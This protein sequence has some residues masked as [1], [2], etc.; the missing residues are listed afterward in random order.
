MRALLDTH[1][2]LWWL[3]DDRRLSERASGV[4]A[5]GAELLFSAASAWEIAIKARL[6]KLVVPEDLEPFLTDQLQR[7]AIE[8]LPVYLSHAMGVYN[9]PDH[10]RDPFDRLL[11]AQCATEDLPLLSADAA[12]ERYPIE[13]IW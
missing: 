2:F 8:V 12:F 4:I 5:D 13:V 3:T 6:G 10:H 1:T 7:E 11:V 9:L